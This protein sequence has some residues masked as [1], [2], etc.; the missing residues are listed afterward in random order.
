MDWAAYRKAQ[1]NS[2]FFEEKRRRH[3]VDFYV[4]VSNARMQFSSNEFC[5]ICD[6]TT[7]RKKLNALIIFSSRHLKL[8][9]Y[10]FVRGF[11]RSCAS[12]YVCL[13]LR[14]SDRECMNIKFCSVFTKSYLI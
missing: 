12:N 14:K 8:K 6:C 13:V 5:N 10:E 4:L 9:G 3:L 2:T 11:L 1:Q 7:I